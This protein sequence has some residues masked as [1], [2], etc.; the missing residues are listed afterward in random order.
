MQNKQALKG[1][2]RPQTRLGYV[3]G[4]GPNCIGYYSHLTK[5]AYVSL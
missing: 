5:T 2:A 1:E 3:Y 4:L